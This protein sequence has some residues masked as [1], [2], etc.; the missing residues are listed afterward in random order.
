M[1][2]YNFFQVFNIYFAY[3][4]KRLSRRLPCSWCFFVFSRGFS[5]ERGL[6]T[7]TPRIVVMIIT[8]AAGIAQGDGPVVRIETRFVAQT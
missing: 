2:F 8:R 6:R 4:C 1:I 5:G 7:A 3:I